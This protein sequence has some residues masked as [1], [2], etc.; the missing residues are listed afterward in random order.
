LQLFA[1][2]NLASHFVEEVF[3]E[4]A[5]ALRLPIQ[6]SLKNAVS[7]MFSGLQ[8]HAAVKIGEARVGAQRS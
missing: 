5:T 2:W 6:N 7:L 1:D 3:S 8:V 4:D